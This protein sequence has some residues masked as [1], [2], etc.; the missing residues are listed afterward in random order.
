MLVRAASGKRNSGVPM[1]ADIT[2]KPDESRIAV[3]LPCAECGYNLRTLATNAR[4]PE[5]NWPVADTLTPPPDA[6]KLLLIAA[7]GVGLAPWL[8][9]IPAAT[10]VPIREGCGTVAILFGTS[11]IAAV[12]LL[13]I[14]RSARI[15]WGRHRFGQ[16]GIAAMFIC[17]VFACINLG[18]TGFALHLAQ[19]TTV[20]STGFDRAAFLAIQPGTALSD[21]ERRIGL[22]LATWTDPNTGNPIARYSRRAGFLGWTHLVIYDA[23]N[24]VVEIRCWRDAD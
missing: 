2:H 15:R 6:S 1:A 11:T 19:D 23:D 20:Y 10:L 13:L 18:V 12:I 21:V 16:R 5:C 4:C 14:G 7:I 22:P 9:Y 8:L 3:D 24:R 17:A